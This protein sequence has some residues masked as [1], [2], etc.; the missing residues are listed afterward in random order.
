MKRKKRRKKR[1][2]INDKVEPKEILFIKNLDGSHWPTSCHDHTSDNQNW[3]FGWSL[4][5]ALHLITDRS[6]A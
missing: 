3:P 1:R 4:T 6:T 5:S 2:E